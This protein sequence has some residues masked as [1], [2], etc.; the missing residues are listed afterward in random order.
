MTCKGMCIRYKAQKPVGKGR[1]ASGQ[2]RCQICE[3]FINYDGYYCPCCGYRL[4]TKPRNLKYKA[5]LRDRQK[6]EAENPDQ[7]DKE[8][9]SVAETKEIIENKKELK[10]EHMNERMEK[11]RLKIKKIEAKRMILEKELSS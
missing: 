10:I 3:T 9:K 1:Y 5:Q 2:K 11:L 4:R 8:N 6:Y 7:I